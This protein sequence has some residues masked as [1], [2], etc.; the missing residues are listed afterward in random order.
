MQITL[1]QAEIEQAITAYIHSQI[2][3]KDGMEIKID[4]SATRGTDGFKATIDIVAA[5]APVVVAEVAVVVPAAKAVAAKT[6]A[7]ATVT[8]VAVKAAGKQPVE[9]K[10][11]VPPATVVVEEELPVEQDPQPEPVDEQSP[12]QEVVEPVEAASDEAPATK[13]TSLFANLRKPNNG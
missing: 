5:T 1:V 7:K 12:E 3:V 8:P 2:N 10:E 13:P 6:E 4:L 9:P 11:E